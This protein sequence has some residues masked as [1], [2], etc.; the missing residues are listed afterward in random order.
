M[1]VKPGEWMYEIPGP[2]VKIEENG[3]MECW[4]PWE[5]AFDESFSHQTILFELNLIENKK[6]RL[7]RV[8]LE[9]SRHASRPSNYENMSQKAITELRESVERAFHTCFS[10]HE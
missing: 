5:R 1:K 8:A 6:G 10:H 3:T 9:G 2:S 4:E 7:I